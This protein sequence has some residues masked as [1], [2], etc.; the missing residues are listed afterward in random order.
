MLSEIELLILCS[1]VELQPNQKT[2]LEKILDQGLDWEKV[3]KRA[4]QECVPPLV[5][6]NLKPYA[7]KIPHEVEKKLNETYLRNL[8]RN[9]VLLSMLKPVLEAVE[10]KGIK[11]ALIKGARLV[12]TIYHDIGERYFIDVDFLVYPSDRYKIQKIL[13]DMGFVQASSEHIHH[14]LSKREKKYWTY[15]PVFRKGKLELELHYNFPGLHMPFSMSQDL[16]KNVQKIDIEGS[17]AQILSPEYELCLLCLHSQQHSYT[18]LDWFTDMAEMSGE[19][20]LDWNKVIEICRKERISASVYY[21]L[22]LVNQLWH[23][24]VSKNILSRFY[25]S[26]LEKKLLGFFWPVESVKSREQKLLFPMHAPTF[27]SI[28][29]RKRPGLFIKALYDFFFPPRSW[30]SLYYGISPNSYKIVIHY[31]WRLWRPFYLL[32]HSLVKTG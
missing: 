3:L 9:I 12:H 19:D 2:E 8:G 7:E 25:V 5:Y 26:F 17:P 27:F 18:R 20:E 30:V 29:S 24:T 1:R 23:G 15:R 11:A 14:E 10:N 16:W 6:K 31:L 32:F 4:S 13:K 22:Y 28:L 21:G